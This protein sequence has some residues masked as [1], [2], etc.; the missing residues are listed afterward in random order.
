MKNNNKSVG[1]VRVSSHTQDDLHGGTGLQFQQEKIKQYSKLHDIDLLDI[2]SDVC[3]G[4]FDTRD[5]IDEVKRM[6]ENGEIERV[7]IWN[8]SRCF[9]SM[10]NFSRF[11]EFLKKYNV[12]LVSVSEGISSFSKHGSMVFGI[13]CSISEYEREI[14]KERMMSGKLTKLKNGERKFGGRMVYGYENKN[15]EIV[16][17]QNESK[18]VKFI[19]SKM[20]KLMKQNLTKTKR[21]QKLLKSL[22]RKG[23]LF[24]GKDFSNQNI[25]SILNNKFYIG[26]MI[27]GDIKTNHVYDT[28]VSK[29]LFN[30][31]Q[32]EISM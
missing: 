2:L 19:F 32:Y 10:L 7:L 23:Y 30:K 15:G 17:N 25:K 20:N 16:V 13:M 28:I 26:E 4:S 18:I 21:T 27:Y 31:V 9:R 12:E 14:I 8:T 6:V 22:R 29:R 11:Y 24:K 3:S 5:G 1:L